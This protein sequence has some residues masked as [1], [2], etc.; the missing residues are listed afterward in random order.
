MHQTLFG[1]NK[2][3][4][5]FCQMRRLGAAAPSSQGTCSQGKLG[6]RVRL[7]STPRSTN[8]SHWLPWGTALRCPTR[9]PQLI[10]RSR[11]L[12]G[13]EATRPW[14]GY[15]ER[16]VVKL[17]SQRAQHRLGRQGRCHPHC[18]PQTAAPEKRIAPAPS[19]LG[20]CKCFPHPGPRAADTAS[21]KTALAGRVDSRGIKGPP[22]RQLPPPEGQQATPAPIH[23][24]PSAAFGDVRQS[25][26]PANQGPINT[27]EPI[28]ARQLHAGGRGKH[29]EQTG[30]CVSIRHPKVLGPG[31]GVHWWGSPELAGRP[32]HQGLRF[33]GAPSSSP[34]TV[35]LPGHCPCHLPSLPPL[36][37]PERLA[38]TLQLRGHVVIV[39][40]LQTQQQLLQV[41]P[42]GRRQGDGLSA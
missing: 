32:L 12:S 21:R 11:V 4:R 2:S 34:V 38:A 26:G 41:L 30:G 15:W 42:G 24:V 14:V 36:L 8:L 23:R 10:T 33:F 5:P 19:P 9:S 29:W 17:G 20:A 18:F 3:S 22:L 1:G 39:Q 40:L 6:A 35:S 16:S 13:S 7:P 25:V 28:V 31:Q 27:D 37:P